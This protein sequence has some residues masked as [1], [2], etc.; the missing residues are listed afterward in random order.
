[1]YYPQTISF[2]TDFKALWASKIA[3]TRISFLILRLF[4]KLYNGYD[5]SACQS[6]LF[7][8]FKDDQALTFRI[9]AE[10]L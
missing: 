3:M 2:K 8:S 5:S 7:Q 1:M 9:A 6:S 10:G 4:I